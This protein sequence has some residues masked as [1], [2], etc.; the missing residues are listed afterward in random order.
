MKND[1]RNKYL[2]FVNI[3]FQM[4]ATIAAGVFA[5]IWLD[6]QFPNKFSAYTISVSLL[7]VF[8]SL[9]LVYREV[10]NLNEDE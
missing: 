4:G 6:K 3:A 10:K 1:K 5:G 2:V 8:I 7:G 9:Y